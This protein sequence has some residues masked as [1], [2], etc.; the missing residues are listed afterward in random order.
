VSVVL[1]LLG[2]PKPLTA[3]DAFWE[4][5][6]QEGTMTFRRSTPLALLVL[7]LA[8]SPPVG[9]A[10]WTAGCPFKQAKFKT[11]PVGKETRTRAISRYYEH[12]GHAVTY[13]AYPGTAPFSTEP[14]GNTVEVTFT[15][16]G[17]GPEIPLPPFTATATTPDAITIVIPDSRPVLGRLLVGPA[18]IRILRDGQVVGDA[19][20]QVI[21]PPMNDVHALATGGTDVEAL[22]ALDRRNLLWIPLTFNGFGSVT[23]PECPAEMTPI[24]PFALDFTLHKGDG[25]AIPHTSFGDLKKNKLFFGDFVLLGVNLYGQKLRDKLDPRPLHGRAVLLCALND[26]LEIVVMIPLGKDADGPSSEIIPIVQDGS[27]VPVKMRN[28]TADPDVATFLAGATADSLRLPC[29]PAP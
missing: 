20:R 29:D 4:A 18:R 7:L 8:G 1:R 26:T 24:V 12:V 13:Y 19:I 15:P 14:D 28:V 23:P 10:K 21:L 25:Q 17:G 3:R 9:A 6:A 27:P 16:L 2:P 22:G 5:Y 11:M